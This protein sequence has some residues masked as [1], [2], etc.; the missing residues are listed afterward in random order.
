MLAKLAGIFYFAA[1][2][3]Y[4][5]YIIIAVAGFFIV[6]GLIRGFF[7]EVLGLVGLVVA[8]ILAT[9]FMSDLSAWID[10]FIDIPAVIATI[11]GFV[12]I[13][14]CVILAFQFIAH[15]LERVFK[16]AMLGWLDKLGGAGVGFLKGATIVSLLLI[17][18]SLVPFGSRLVPGLP[19]SRYYEPAR[20]FA[21][22]LFNLIM[23]V[24]PGSKSFYVEV[25][26]SLENFSPAELAR[27]AQSFL[28]ALQNNESPRTNHSNNHEQS[29]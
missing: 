28:K 14:F 24:V 22:K 26:E 6:R 23:E 25:K 27:N 4:V 11:L 7:A 10:R 20:N 21:P 16:S 13:F 2:M 18:I 8:L 3:N 17:F 9:K 5:D 19:E 29:R 12:V 15:M 1:T